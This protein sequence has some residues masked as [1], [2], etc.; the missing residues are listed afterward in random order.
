MTGADKAKL[1]GVAASATA[2]PL[3]SAAPQPLGTADDGVGT[4][5]SR[6]DHVHEHGNQSSDGNMHAAA[7]AGAAAGFMSGADKLAV[8]TFFSALETRTGAGALGI[9]LFA[10]IL[11]PT[12]AAEAVTLADGAFV[13]QPKVI[14]A[15]SGY[16]AG[17]STVVTPATANGYTTITFPNASTTVGAWILLQWQVVGWTV[18]MHGGGLNSAGPTVA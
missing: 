14:R 4:S 16:S 5:A 9:T 3:S 17:N 15:G 18:L 2:T 11:A 12:G 6:D 10:S 1:D 8:D 7:I 13:G